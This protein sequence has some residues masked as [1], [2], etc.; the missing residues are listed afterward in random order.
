MTH[1]EI[2]TIKLK[3][4]RVNVGIRTYMTSGFKD[5]KHRMIILR[6]Q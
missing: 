5:R 1:D 3:K 4:T 6:T 2:N